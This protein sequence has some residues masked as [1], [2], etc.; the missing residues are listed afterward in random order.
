MQRFRI[1]NAKLE[2]L[3][4][5][6]RLAK[7]L[8]TVNLPDET[9]ALFEVLQRS[10]RSFRGEITDPFAR[11]YVFVLEMATQ[12]HIVGSSQ[13]MAQHG[14]REAPHIFFDVS[15]SERYSKSIDR[16]FRHQILRLGYNYDGPTEIGGLIVDPEYRKGHQKLGLQLS[17]VRFLFIAMH[18]ALF[19]NRVLAEMLPPLRPNGQ[20]L[21]WEA[22]GRRFTGLDYVTAD[23]ISRTNKEFI[24]GL[25]PE[26]PIYSC[27]LGKEVEAVIGEVG[28]GSQPAKR[29]LESI[30]FRYQNRVDPFDGGP[31]FEANCDDVAPISKSVTLKARRSLIPLGHKERFL[32]AT[33]TAPFTPEARFLATVVEG[34]CD[35][36]NGSIMLSAE[37]FALLEASEDTPLQ[38]YPL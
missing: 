7:S 19:K 3:A 24:E 5:L 28:E 15:V 21:L 1:R 8:N 16:H 11:E 27:L 26:D 22:L 37:D 32:A 25:F 13:V 2:D 23:H 10:E 31:H 38:L 20:S 12:G 30:G 35:D 34:K 29:L 14:T 9:T 36:A 4:A 18:R 17:L 33:F 6:Q